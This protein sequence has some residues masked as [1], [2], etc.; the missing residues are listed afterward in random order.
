MPPTLSQS[1]E[2][3]LDDRAAS[4]LEKVYGNAQSDIRS[5][6]SEASDLQKLDKQ[7]LAR[8]LGEVNQI[9]DDLQDRGAAWARA[10]TPRTF[11]NGIRLASARLDLEAG[12]MIEQ[13]D[14][15]A[16][17]AIAGQIAADL[18]VANDGVKRLAGRYI[19]ATQQKL[20]EESRINELI[21]EG[22]ISG[23]ARRTVSKSIIGELETAVGEGK[24]IPINCQDGKVRHYTMKAYGRM[25]A[26]AKMRQASTEG[27]VAT[28]EQIGN[29]LV[30]VSIHT[31]SCAICLP[32]QGKVYSITGNDPDFPPLE[33]RPPWHPHCRHVLLPVTREAL[34]ARGELES[35]SENSKDNDFEFAGPED[36]KQRIQ[37]TEE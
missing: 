14:R 28:C 13:I 8:I 32:Y 33:S 29:T 5:R 36:Y 10:V 19:R 7:A 18:G 23:D 21:A 25:V 12:E 37:D 6:L 34:E 11:D 20:I 22:L 17:T 1:E 30:Q 27:V 26:T 35:L 31:G 16:V 3:M 9:V 24:L 4:V 2:S 15:E